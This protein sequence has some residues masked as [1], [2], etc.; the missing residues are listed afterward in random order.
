MNGRFMG[1]LSGFCAVVLFLLFITGNRQGVIS[2]DNGTVKKE[3]PVIVID[4]GHGGVFPGK[5]RR[6]V[7][8]RR[9][10]P[11]LQDVAGVLYRKR[12]ARHHDTHG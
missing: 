1:L 8:K 11:P 5:V 4:A 6:I 2:A 10:S 9:Q 7:R 3:T 12:L